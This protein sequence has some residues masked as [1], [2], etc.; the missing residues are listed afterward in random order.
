MR[1]F[2]Q[3]RLD[4]HGLFIAT[5]RYARA[6]HFDRAQ[7]VCSFCNSG[8]LGDERHLIFDCAALAFLR[9]RYADLFPD[10]TQTMRSFFT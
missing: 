7:R 4:C 2:L 10:S 8:A 3:F 5:G 6:A 1:R 9:S